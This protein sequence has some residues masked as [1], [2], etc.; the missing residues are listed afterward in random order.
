[1]I[2]FHFSTKQIYGCV[3][4]FVLMI[5]LGIQCMSFPS[6]FYFS[7]N[8]ALALHS[9]VNLQVE[10]GDKCSNSKFVPG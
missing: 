10:M 8:F 4:F 2:P 6:V 7:G 9:S 5:V 3:F 1:M